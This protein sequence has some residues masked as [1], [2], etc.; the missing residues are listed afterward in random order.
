MSRGRVTL[1]RIPLAH[2]IRAVTEVFFT[3]LV[4]VKSLGGLAGNETQIAHGTEHDRD[5]DRIWVEMESE[6]GKDMAGGW[7]FEFIRESC[8]GNRCVRG[9]RTRTAASQF[10]T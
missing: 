8:E 7:A 9:K 4:C 2:G 3:L 10:P 1:I 6:S 5:R